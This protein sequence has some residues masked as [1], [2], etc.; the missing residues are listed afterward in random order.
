MRKM[1]RIIRIT[2]VVT[3]PTTKPTTSCNLS[4]KE[5][6]DCMSKTDLEW[7]H[8]YFLHNV[9]DAIKVV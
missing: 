3:P 8:D 1:A 9:G 4:L 7:N 2:N 5:K 6:I